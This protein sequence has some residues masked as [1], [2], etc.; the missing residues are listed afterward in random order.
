[1]QVT[2]LNAVLRANL[3]SRDEAIKDVE[4]GIRKFHEKQIL[5]LEERIKSARDPKEAASLQ[6]AV[7]ELRTEIIPELR[8]Q[9]PRYKQ[10]KVI[11]WAK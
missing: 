3:A 6:K 9:I 5:N 7:H 11:E 8:A 4:E 10:T 2:I 1:V